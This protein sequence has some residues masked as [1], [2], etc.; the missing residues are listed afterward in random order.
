MKR[1]MSVFFVFIVGLI[2][3][4]AQISLP[5]N[6]TWEKIICNI[7]PN[8]IKN[9]GRSI[10]YFPQL[11]YSDEYISV[12]SEFNDYD[13]VHI[14]ITNAQSVVVKDEFINVMAGDENL[15]YIGDLGCGEYVIS[16]ETIEFVM[17]GNFDVK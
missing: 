3:I 10:V 5:S 4:N 16:F 12:Q 14:I 8:I 9:K 13:N 1:I 7:Y 2:S 6:I 17:I 11:Y 15:Y